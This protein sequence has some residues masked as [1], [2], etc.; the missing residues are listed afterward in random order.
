MQ[1]ETHAKLREILGMFAP[2]EQVLDMAIKQIDTVYQKEMAA[3]SHQHL[4]WWTNK[5]FT[6]DDDPELRLPRGTSVI[7]VLH[8]FGEYIEGFEPEVT[9]GRNRTAPSTPAGGD[10]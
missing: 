7:Q 9:D 1:D 3:M 2:N 4:L 5:L 6:F 8:E 10:R